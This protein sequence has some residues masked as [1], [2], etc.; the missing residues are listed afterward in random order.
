MNTDLIWWIFQQKQFN[1]STEIGIKT[2]Y[3]ESL[4]YILI[5]GEQEKLI[6]PN[7]CHIFRTNWFAGLEFLH[8]KVRLIV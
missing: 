3:L 7:I 8:K 5:H 2:R 1:I 4:Q 6:Q